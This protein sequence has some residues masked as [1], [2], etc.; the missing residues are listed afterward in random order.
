MKISFRGKFLQKDRWAIQESKLNDLFLLF[1][2]KKL[3]IMPCRLTDFSHLSG[4]FDIKMETKQL[5][6]LE[7]IKEKFKE[8]GIIIKEM[9]MIKREF[10]EKELKELRTSVC[11]KEIFKPSGDK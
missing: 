1:L 3:E 2:P 8:R 4:W 11:F 10:S 9:T 7:D 5:F 6:T